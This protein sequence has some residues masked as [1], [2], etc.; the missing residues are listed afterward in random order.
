M[1]DPDR[2]KE[3]ESADSG[4]DGERPTGGEDAVSLA[5][6]AVTVASVLLTLGVFLTVGW[7]AVGGAGAVPPTVDVV[8][9]EGDT[10]DVSLWNP[11]SS[12]FASV[13]VIVHCGDPPRRFTFEHVPASGTAEGT[14]RCPPAEGT[15]TAEVV[16]WIRP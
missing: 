16:Q 4:D 9:A 2:E 8:A 3:E 5:E 10:Y 6:R 1:G 11:G 12:G 7:Q 13:T 15:P 14:V